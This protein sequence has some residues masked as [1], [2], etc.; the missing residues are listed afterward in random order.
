MT[1]CRSVLVVEFRIHAAQI[2]AFAQA[3]AANA[4]ASLDNEPGCHIFDV[5][6]DPA[7]PALFYL[8][9]V[10]A[11]DAAVSAHL[12]SPHFMSMNAE[13]AAWVI[14]KAVRLL[15]LPGAREASE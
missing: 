2:E 11:D 14:S 8:Y 13:T 7:E 5:C 6:R 12:Q 3:I 1:T 9:E 10:Y 4:R 15:Q